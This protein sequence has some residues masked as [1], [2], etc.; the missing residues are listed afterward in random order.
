MAKVHIK[1]T[2]QIPSEGRKGTESL[3]FDYY[4]MLSMERFQ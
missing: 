3:N 2:Y 1:R 4:K